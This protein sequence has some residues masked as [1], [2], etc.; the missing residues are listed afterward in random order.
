M[1]K[2]YGINGVITGKL[3]AAVYA[4]RNGE[5][6]S[7]QYQPVV[8]NPR[9]QG[10]I[11]ARA[12]LKL[13]SQL[14]A[15]LAPVIAIPKRGP[16]ST[17]NLFVKKN[18]GTASYATD[19]A[20]VDLNNVKLTDSVVGL[21]AVSATRGEENIEVQLASS[22]EPLGL[23]RVVYV[24]LQKQSDNELRLYGTKVVTE[25]GP[26]NRY[27]ATFRRTLDEV[28]VYAYGVRDNT[29]AASAKFGEIH[30]LTGEQVASLV[31]SKTLTEADITL[32]ETRAVTVAAGGPTMAVNAPA[33]E[34]V[35]K[36]K[37]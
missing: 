1:A 20:S 4:V 26:N 37:S 34:P 24:M 29:N 6:I 8:A 10:Q 36:A 25:A 21:P 32:T 23:S 22:L 19:T 28:V 2:I 33:N 3:G 15:V 35:R 16:V 5:Q 7:R 30:A 9:T 27:P 14:S 13:M 17:R 11:A 18:Y 31:V 12:K